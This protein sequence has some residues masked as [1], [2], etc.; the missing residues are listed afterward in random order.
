VTL[1]RTVWLS[2]A[3]GFAGHHALEHILSNTDWNVICTDSFRHKGTTDRITDVFY[4]GSPSWTNRVD[5]IT[6]DL[7]A[8]FAARQVAAMGDVDYMVCYA[9]ESHVDRSID[10]PVPFIRNNVDVALNSL[11]LARALKPKQVIWISTDEV[12]GPVEATDLTGHSE[13]SPMLPSN[14]Y[15][16]SKAAQE[17]IAISYWRTYGVPLVIVNCMNMI[18]ER[19]DEKFV[20]TTIAR[21]LRGE[22]VKIHARGTEIGT[23]HYLH[24]RNLADGV[25]HL[26]KNT[27]PARYR[28]W[29]FADDKPPVTRPDR[30]NIATPDR[31]DNL[32]LAQMI[33]D[34]A[35]KHLSYQF[36]DFHS[37]RPGHDPHYGLNPFKMKDIGWESP[38]P[39]EESLERTV[40]WTMLH[41]EWLPS[42]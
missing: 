13:W 1:T 7:T 2:G 37:A 34:Y 12:Y 40:K 21:V 31:I 28:D 35:G 17:D 36:E 26:L 32:T 16:A 33:A 11:E 30:Y 15:A 9:S 5:V 38:V 18:G 8:P 22:T 23:R 24:A 20:P 4:G 14:P 42:L 19:Q 41:P 39:F 10:D 27:V 3:G 6:H 29:T 25:L